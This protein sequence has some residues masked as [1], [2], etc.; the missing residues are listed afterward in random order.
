MKLSY[1]R[2]VRPNHKAVKSRVAPA[3][4]DRFM[5]SVIREALFAVKTA[6][7]NGKAGNN[8]L[9]TPRRPSRNLCHWDILNSDEVLKRDVYRAMDS[10]RGG[11]GRRSWEILI[12]V[13]VARK[14]GERE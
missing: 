4:Y 7:S 2:L 1:F 8:F 10:A 5:Q 6:T 13:I 14:L 11:I 3:D 12:N 9:Y